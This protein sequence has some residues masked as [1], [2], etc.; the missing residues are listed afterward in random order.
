M[1]HTLTLSLPFT[2]PFSVALCLSSCLTVSALAQ[3]CLTGLTVTLALT[4]HLACISNAIPLPF[5]LSLPF[6]LPFRHKLCL[7]RGAWVATAL[8][9]GMVRC[10]GKRRREWLGHGA[11]W[12]GIEG[13]V[14][15]VVRLHERVAGRGRFAV[16][17]LLTFSFPFTLAFPEGAHHW[18]GGNGGLT[19]VWDSGGNATLIITGRCARRGSASVNRWSG[20]AVAEWFTFAELLSIPLTF[21]FPFPVRMLDAS[22]VGK[23]INMVWMM[24]RRR[25]QH[26]RWWNMGTRMRWK[27]HW[28]LAWMLVVIR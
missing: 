14:V 4:H 3:A 20:K 21:T 22:V 12:A 13:S 1:V 19:T 2:I 5:T 15:C 26:W 18:L 8:R 23:V 17:E 6:A 16:A 28:M 27:V 9:R 10:Q 24:R 25:R 11:M 7:D